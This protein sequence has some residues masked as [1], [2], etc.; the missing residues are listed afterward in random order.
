M[1]IDVEIEKRGLNGRQGQDVHGILR[2]TGTVQPVDSL[3]GLKNSIKQDIA[4]C[5]ADWE[6]YECS[7]KSCK[8]KTF[9]S[10]VCIRGCPK[11]SHK[12]QL[13]LALKY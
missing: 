6:N 1:T 11:L 5:Y 7:L 3:I 2:P 13:V 10:G 9:L 12:K 8:S 4:L